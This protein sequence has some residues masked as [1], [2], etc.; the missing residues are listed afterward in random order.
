VCRQIHDEAE[1]IYL[2]K[3]LF[4]LPMFWP[5]FQPIR[6]DSSSFYHHYR[7][8][9]TSP[10]ERRHLFS[11]KG[12]IYVKNISFSFDQL[13]LSGTYGRDFDY[14]QCRKL[15][16]KQRS[17]EQL[18]D[19]ERFARVHEPELDLVMGQWQELTQYL[20]Q[21]KNLI[22]YLEIDFS[23]AFCPFGD[24][25][26]VSYGLHTWIQYLD[27]ISIDAIGLYEHEQNDFEFEDSDNETVS[28]Q[29]C[30]DRF[31]LRFRSPEDPTRWDK[32]MMDGEVDDQEFIEHYV[33]PPLP[34]IPRD[35]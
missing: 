24:C 20:Q 26:P 18:S 29:D 28:R 21:F 25:R 6:T 33:R 27:P 16:Y 1:P 12:L 32:W 31:G 30:E 23:N 11:A 3:N 34:I 14:W 19:T 22:D 35:P 8:D 4:V 13:D 9:N 17:F 2:S 7:P 10:H 5:A 15:K